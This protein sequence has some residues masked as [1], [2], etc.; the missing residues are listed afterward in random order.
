MLSRSSERLESA[1]PAEPFDL[2]RAREG[3]PAE[4]LAPGGVFFA[5]ASFESG[6]DH[7]DH[8]Y[9]FESPVAIPE[10]FEQLGL[11]PSGHNTWRKRVGSARL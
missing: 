6:A 11:D 9:H 1:R 3:R 2:R 8:P 5:T 7:P 4:V 10:F